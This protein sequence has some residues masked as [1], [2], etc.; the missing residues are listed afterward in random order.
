[1]QLNA[2]ILLFF[3]VDCQLRVEL[4]NFELHWFIG[5]NHNFS[6]NKIERKVKCAFRRTNNDI[7]TRHPR[8]EP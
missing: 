6:K 1:M 5:W 2:T 8:S 3:V 4:V 7:L